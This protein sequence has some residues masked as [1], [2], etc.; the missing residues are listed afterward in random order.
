MVRLTTIC[1]LAFLSAIAAADPRLPATGESLPLSGAADW[2]GLQWL[3]D[4]PSTNDAAGK[5]VVH[6]FCSAKPASCKDDLERI[7]ALRDTNHV[8]VVGYIAGTSYAAK[9]LDP[10]KESEGVGRG[11][12]AFGPNV[13]KLA[14]QLGVTEA[15][16]V[17]DIDGKVKAVTT[18]GDLNELD[19]RDKLVTQLI[20]AIKEYTITSSGPKSSKPNEKFPLSIKVELSSW[21]RFKPDA[22]AIFAL[23]AP[24]DV[25][26]EKST[27]ID[28]RTLTA[29]ASCSGPKGSY[30]V[31]GKLSFGYSTPS[32]DGLGQDGTSWKFEIK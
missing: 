32:G 16:I 26:C 29:T 28:G 23:T 9:Q 8:Y 21:L 2:P 17:V 24:K 4:A 18:S 6:W 19:A 31:Q 7:I 22:T 25:K 20:D 12:V 14:K 1:C 3:Y 13:A 11:T 15:A 30:E 5:I 27:K 10:I